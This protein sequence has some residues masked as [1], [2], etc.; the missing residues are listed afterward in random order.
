MLE[1]VPQSCVPPAALQ[2]TLGGLFSNGPETEHSPGTVTLAFSA[3]LAVPGI[4]PRALHALLKC[5]ILRCLLSPLSFYFEIGAYWVTQ[6]GL[7]LFCTS[8]LKLQFSCLCLL[9][10]WD[11]DLWSRCPL[12]ICESLVS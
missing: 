1:V 5:T 7:E 2:V 9:S 8:G 10:R 12:I 4:K 6:A 3:Y 11:T